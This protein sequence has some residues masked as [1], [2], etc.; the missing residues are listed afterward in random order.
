MAKSLIS[1]SLPDKYMIIFCNK[2]LKGLNFTDGLSKKY[3]ICNFGICSINVCEHEKHNSR[4]YNLHIWMLLEISNDSI[5]KRV[6][7]R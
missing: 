6:A 2:Q 3:F 1:I 4:I 7:M 5:R